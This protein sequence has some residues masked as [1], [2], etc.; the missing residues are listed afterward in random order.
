MS[1]KI[2]KIIWNQNARN[3]DAK[4]KMK[5]EEK[6]V[7]IVLNSHMK[8]YRVLE[9]GDTEDTYMV[10]GYVW[11]C[12]PYLPSVKETKLSPLV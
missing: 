5:D 9:M 6:K 7:L 10:F 12:E 4:P 2:K 11:A 1:Q 3:R 8:L